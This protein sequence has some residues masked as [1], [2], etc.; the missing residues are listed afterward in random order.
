M[1]D[2]RK[3]SFRRLYIKLVEPWL[4]EW[5]QQQIIKKVLTI[6]MSSPN[7]LQPVSFQGAVWPQLF[8][9][10][11]VLVDCLTWYSLVILW[12][13][14]NLHHS[15]CLMEFMQTCNKLMAF[16]STSG[17]CSSIRQDTRSDED[18]QSLEYLQMVVTGNPPKKLQTTQRWP[19]MH[20]IQSHH[21]KVQQLIDCLPPA[22]RAV[23]PLRA[24]CKN[25][26]VWYWQRKQSG[27]G[28]RQS[29]LSALGNGS[30]NKVGE[31][32]TGTEDPPDLTFNPGWNTCSFLWHLMFKP[33]RTASV[34]KSFRIAKTVAEPFA[35]PF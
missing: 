3:H 17:Y 1:R 25:L 18:P 33:F 22:C 30:V 24:N 4:Q 8:C 19:F 5:H 9:C 35:S 23:H 15:E 14:I 16:T 34:F 13:N 28:A 11:I 10:I 32:C 7:N 2:I 29:A 12:S 27:W 6:P 31:S 20:K 26:G 21:C